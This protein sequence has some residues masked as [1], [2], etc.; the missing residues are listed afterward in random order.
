KT[1]T[2]TT[3]P[4]LDGLPAEQARRLEQACSQFEAAWKD[5]QAR[6]R[7][8]LVEY[9]ADTAEPARSVLL[10]ELLLVELAYRRHAGDAP[11][12]AGCRPL[13]PEDEPLLR[14]VFARAGLKTEPTALL[15]SAGARPPVWLSVPTT[16]NGGPGLPPDAPAQTLPGV[17]GLR[18]PGYEI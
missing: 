3:L 8:H 9:L 1:M 15:P 2:D 4:S 13:C 17:D 18:I 5:W 6:P 12:L 10:C 11:P 14:R 7:P 16:R